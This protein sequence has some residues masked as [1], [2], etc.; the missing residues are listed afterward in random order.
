[1][2]NPFQKRNVIVTGGSR[3]LGREIALEFGRAGDRVVV[4]YQSDERSAAEVINEIVRSGGQ[5]FQFKADVS[6]VE[7]VNS[8]F[9]ETATRWDSIEVLVNNAGITSDRL[10][11]KMGEQEWDSV[12]DTNLKGPFNTIRAMTRLMSGLRRGH[13]INI[14]SIVG[15]QGR[16]GQANYAS[17]KAALIGLTKASAK[18]LGTFNIQVNAVLPGY[19][20]TRMGENVS[21]A[22]LERVLKENAL[23]RVSD[24]AEVARFIYN[25]SFMKNVSGQVFNLDSRI[26]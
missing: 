23:N 14:A 20:P 8:M 15:L 24:P 3:G 11:L 2:Q 17:A 5:A 10:L 21:P 7:E 6:L 19:L 25:L 1:M 13:I 16:E 18:E 12:L 22:V 4:N 26:L 9:D